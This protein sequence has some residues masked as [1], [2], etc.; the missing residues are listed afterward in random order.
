MPPVTPPRGTSNTAPNNVGSL[1]PSGFASNRQQDPET[2]TR[3]RGNAPAEHHGHMLQ[4]PAASGSGVGVDSET[5]APTGPN[6]PTV[7]PS[8]PPRPS[9]PVKNITPSIH[10]TSEQA[11]AR[12]GHTSVENTRGAIETD[13][14]MPGRRIRV[15]FM[16]FLKVLL[17]RCARSPDTNIDT[18]LNDLIDNCVT[19]CNSD[20]YKEIAQ[21][22]LVR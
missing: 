1:T 19:F 16:D 22:D 13:I 17:K 9:L 18:L 2:P 3:S 8:T 7:A 5:P 21:R 20:E 4:T 15:D 10:G 14:K 12:S 11:Q 6:N